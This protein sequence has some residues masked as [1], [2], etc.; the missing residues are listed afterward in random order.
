MKTITIPECRIVEIHRKTYNTIL[1]Y[2]V[3]IIIFFLVIALFYFRGS[4]SSLFYQYTTL[5]PYRGGDLCVW[6]VFDTCLQYK[7][8][9]MDKITHY[10]LLHIIYQPAIIKYDFWRIHYWFKTYLFTSGRYCTI[11]ECPTIIRIGKC[12]VK[13]CALI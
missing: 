9:T 7:F 11:C 8:F 6:L 5:L 3:Y 12:A 10:H 13:F 4:F 2:V 1:F